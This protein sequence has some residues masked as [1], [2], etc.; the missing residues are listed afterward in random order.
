MVLGQVTELTDQNI[1]L[2][3][4]NNLVGYVPI[5]T[6]SDKLTARLEKLAQEDD[7]EDAGNADSEDA[8]DVDL[9]NMFFAG[10][11]L[12]AYV[13]ATTEDALANGITKTKKRI[14]LSIHPKLVN[15]GIE[16]SNL[17]AN[18]MIQASVVSNED[19]GLVMDMGLED[20]Q[21]KGFLSKSELGSQI[22]H[23]KVQ[24]GA[25]FMCLVSGLNPDGRI[26]KLSADQAKAG[27]LKKS[28][29]LTKAP[30]I[31]VFLPGTAVEM[32]VLDSTPNTITGKVMGLVDATAD[33][34][35][36]GA[37][38]KGED[39]S[40][41]YKIGSKVNAR[42][43][44]TCPDSDPK[45]VGISLLEHVVSLSSRM[46][47][48]PKQKKQ[49]LEILPIASFVEEAKVTKVQPKVG[50]YF[51][52]GVRDVVGYAHISK[53]ADEL[54]VTTLSTVCFRF[55]WNKKCWINLFS[56]LMTYA[57]AR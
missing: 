11:Y 56:A 48:K 18:S 25:V 51:D 15:R 33:I 32:L 31:D 27:N 45:K 37:A 40:E 21:L 7:E 26:V 43:I 8:E 54:S 10:Q 24:E 44:F 1:V 2:S 35:H 19:H 16:K 5:T 39:V 55:R 23:A 6:I 3:L 17:V 30:T 22:K 42:M 41:K 50:V 53:L 52:L 20:A 29:I 28:N 9:K 12:R 47:G 38:E 57:S 34:I 13:T 46:S 14:E 4:P 36:S 49:P